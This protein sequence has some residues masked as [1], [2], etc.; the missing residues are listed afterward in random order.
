MQVSARV[1]KNKSLIQQVVVMGRHPSPVFV[2]SHV[3][4]V[5]VA[6]VMCDRLCDVLSSVHYHPSLLS[7][8]RLVDYPI[9][10]S[11]VVEGRN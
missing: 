2:L 3:S 10:L 1:D 8:G 5:V 4:F 6:F 11:V 9:C 7:F